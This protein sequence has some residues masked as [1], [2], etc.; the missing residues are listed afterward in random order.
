M[1]WVW[2]FLPL[3]GFLVN[4]G[5]LAALS[6]FGTGLCIDFCEEATG[7]RGFVSGWDPEHENL[8]ALPPLQCFQA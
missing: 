8:G 5:F 2:A 7:F 1:F 6:G 3:S 4:T